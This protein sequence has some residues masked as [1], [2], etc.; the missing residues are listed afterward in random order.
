[1]SPVELANAI[2]SGTA[3]VVVD[4]RSKREFDSGH[5]PGAIHLP[6]WKIGRQSEKLSTTPEQ[7]IVVYCGHGPRAYIA[8]AALRQCGFMN[9]AYLTG[10]MKKWKEMKLP[11]T[12]ACLMLAV[13]A[14]F[15]Q[16]LD[17]RMVGVEGEGAKYWPVWR[18][19]SGQGLVTGTYTD[20]W[21]S[22]ENVVW[23]K[24]V[25]GRGNS[26][27]IVWGD[28][29]FLTTAHD[30][31]RRVSLIAFRRSDGTPLWE[32]F[33][34]EGRTGRAHYKNGHASATPSTDGS[35]VYASFGS[36]GLAAF[37]FNG[38]LVWHKDLG[39]VDNYHGAAG[40][41]L[42][43]KDRVILYQDFD[44]G[45]FV[46]AFDTKT[47]KE[48]WRTPRRAYVGWGTPVAVRVAARDEIIVSSQ[49][50]VTAYD[51]D[52]GKELWVCDGNS[53]EVIPTPVVGHGLVFAASGRV[54]PTLA[55]RPGGRGNVTRTHLAW[56]SPKGSPFVPSP[57]IYGDQLYM[58]NDMASIVTAFEAATGKVL[59]QGR[60]GVAQREGFSAS[61][62]AV[63][64]KVF[65]TNDQGET[66]VLRAGP[67]F[68]LLRTN[69][70]GESTLASPALVEGR[71]YIR[72]DRSLFSIGQGN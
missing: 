15:A 27:P 45:S 56:S 19:P 20:T 16:Q 62:V 4:V 71:W 14:A 8:A 69:N 22:T 51:P 65:F 18:G 21:S 41:P 23:K 72:T 31:G 50:S 37:D 55:I 36:R 43:Y 2:A 34:P 40:S 70:I 57:I 42:L 54:G 61:P 7:P 9:V 63:D 5:V 32:T 38:K 3:P 24:P 64:M 58:V 13:A 29:I 52:S 53:F 1:M 26:S 11:L 30:G 67:T 39:D 48:L 46:A 17:V 33:A 49:S 47:G 35:L 59:W 44:S 28:R 66:F 12:I 68:E 60:L 10:H 25:A 6:F